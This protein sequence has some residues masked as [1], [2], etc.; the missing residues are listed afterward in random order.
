RR[1]RGL[2]ADDPRTWPMRRRGERD[3]GDEPAAADRDH[4]R[5]DV[6]RVR[7]QLERERALSRDHVVVIERV[8]VRA[9]ALVRDLERGGVRVV[10]ALTREH[11][12]RADALDRRELRERYALRQYDGGGHPEEP[13][14][15]RDALSVVPRGRG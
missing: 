2:H 8:H 15:V 12:L 10:V 5:V 13:R 7:E 6:R 14:R 1:P 4:E 11:G 9:P 3:T